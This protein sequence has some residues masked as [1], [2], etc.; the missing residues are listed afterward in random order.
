MRLTLFLSLHPR[1]QA[2][3]REPARAQGL[4]VAV[5]PAWPVVRTGGDY[6]SDWVFLPCGRTRTH[7]RLGEPPR[8][9]AAPRPGTC[10]GSPRRWRATSC[11][12]RAHRNPHHRQ[13]GHDGGPQEVCLRVFGRRR[14]R[15]AVVWTQRWRRGYER[16]SPDLSQ[17]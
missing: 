17:A 1:V 15:R 5:R 9:A 3:P 8:A 11:S 6:G 2:A 4:R 14:R 13:G 12:T 10:C 7:C 16:R